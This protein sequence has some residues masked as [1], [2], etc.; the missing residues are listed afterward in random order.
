[1]KTL[2]ATRSPATCYVAIV[3][4]MEKPEG[5]MH[6][7]GDHREGQT[8]VSP[9]VGPRRGGQVSPF[10]DGLG[11]IAGPQYL[12]LPLSRPYKGQVGGYNAENFRAMTMVHPTHRCLMKLSFFLHHQG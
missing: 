6:S 7:M 3:Q 2:P 11:A 9:Y 4:K 10:A 1:L 12:L 8:T 5:I